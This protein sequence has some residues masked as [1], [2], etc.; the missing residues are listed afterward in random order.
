MMKRGIN[1]LIWPYTAVTM[2]DKMNHVCVACEGIVCGERLDMYTAQAS[3]LAEFAPGRPLLE[4]L[5]VA[6][7]SFFDEEVVRRIVF[8]HAKFIQDRFHL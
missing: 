8:T 2:L 3:F 6:R 7:D 4:M 1:T 5:V